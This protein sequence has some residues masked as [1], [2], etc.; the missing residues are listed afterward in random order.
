MIV[1]GNRLL[2]KKKEEENKSKIILPESVVKSVFYGEVIQTGPGLLREDG[3]RVPMSVKLG[4]NVAFMST[5]GFHLT[6]DNGT[7]TILN[8]RDVIGIVE[9]GD[10]VF[11]TEE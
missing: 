7:F 9:E 5:T 8:E 3:S 2:I 6:T 10:L 4:D 1:L 11:E